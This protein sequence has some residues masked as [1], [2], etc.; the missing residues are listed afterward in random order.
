MTK[1]AKRF[2]R[3]T[4]V[5][6]VTLTVAA[7]CIATSVPTPE[8]LYKEENKRT[9]TQAVQWQL[10]FELAN[11]YLQYSNNRRFLHLV[12]RWAWFDEIAKGY[13]IADLVRQTINTRPSSNDSYEPAFTRLVEL[14][15]AGNISAR[16]FAWM[17]HG[18]LDKRK[19]KSWK[20]SYED[21][22]RLALESKDSGHPICKGI[23]GSLYLYGQLGY[24]QSKEKAKPFIIE[25]AL[26]GFYGDLKYLAGAN[27]PIEGK[28][29][30]KKMALELCWL[31]QANRQSHTAYFDTACSVY[32]EG[33]AMNSKMEYFNLSEEVKATAQDWCQTSGPKVNTTAQDCAELEKSYLK[34]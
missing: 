24:P 27:S 18:H 33:R 21:A 34:E 20:Y 13:E 23:E 17:I 7:T 22:A 11:E 2:M 5:L 10:D 12:D 16:C 8:A 3:W 19:T 4:T 28:N 26:I 15:K 1:F 6:L 14:G 29:D 25:S 31:R 32:L 9:M 30:S